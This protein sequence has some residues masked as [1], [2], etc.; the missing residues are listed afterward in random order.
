MSP[1]SRLPVRLRVTLAFA[2]VM[3][4]VLAATGLFVYL[5]LASELDAAIDR[6]LRSRAGDVTALIKQADSG[7][8]QS[9]RSPLTEQGQNLAQ[10]L[11]AKGRIVDSTP[12]LRK[13]PLLSDAQV[14]RALGGPV[15]INT[16]TVED[17]ARLLAT[18]VS[19][20]DQ[21]LV[22][23]VGTT[24]EDRDNALSSLGNL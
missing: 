8:A 18:P 2:G 17:G 3:A 11:D 6:G 9:G 5:R 19:A 22:V 1:F 7:L 13:Q 20:Q 16:S 12:S 4:L 15:Y 14:S 24:L 23:V 10:I 21:R